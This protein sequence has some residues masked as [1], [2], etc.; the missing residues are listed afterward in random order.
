[1]G[2]HVTAL[3]ATLWTTCLTWVEA[4]QAASI[5]SLNLH[6]A[7][8]KA[9]REPKAVCCSTCQAATNILTNAAGGGVTHW[10]CSRAR[11]ISLGGKANGSSIARD[12]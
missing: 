12:T 1:M 9:S 4:L 11:G 2:S 7:C 3:D 6:G 8:E 5:R 10:Y